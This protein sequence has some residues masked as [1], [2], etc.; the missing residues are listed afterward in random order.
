MHKYLIACAVSLLLCVTCFALASE[1]S[2]YSLWDVA[3]YLL[4]GLGTACLLPLVRPR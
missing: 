3:G 2:L 1:S 4:A